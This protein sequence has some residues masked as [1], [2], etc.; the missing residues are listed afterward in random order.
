MKLN[1]LHLIRRILSR[2]LAGIGRLAPRNIYL[3]DRKEVNLL[4]LINHG[5]VNLQ[6]L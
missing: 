1:Y 3:C 4:R 6:E 2:R 5:I